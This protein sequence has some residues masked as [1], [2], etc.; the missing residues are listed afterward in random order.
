MKNA[1][2][3]WYRSQPKILKVFF[4]PLCISIA[5]ILLKYKPGGG[6]FIVLYAISAM[7][8]IVWQLVNQY[9]DAVIEDDLVTIKE[10]RDQCKEL[11]GKLYHFNDVL[12]QLVANKSEI[13]L[14]SLSIAENSRESAIKFIRD[15]TY[16]ENIDRI[17]G[18]IYKV[19]EKEANTS[20]QQQF[21][22]SYLMPNNNGEAL[23]IKSWYNRKG[24]TPRS[25]TEKKQFLKNDNTL[26]GYLWGRNQ[27]CRIIDNVDEHISTEKENTVFSYLHNDERHEIKSIICYNVREPEGNLCLGIISIDTNING[28][29]EKNEAF[30]K[31]VLRSFG[32][33]IIFETRFAAMRETLRPQTEE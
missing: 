12:N 28:F 24:E 14:N 11:F 33:R 6:N 5:L 7:L 1:Y 31:E 4:L 19:F 29:F 10:D 16:K 3:N 23:V 9:L 8:L 13:Y 22:V 32:K 26:A 21:R 2:I 18:M 20:I 27:E 30:Y 15:Y 25:L 17:I